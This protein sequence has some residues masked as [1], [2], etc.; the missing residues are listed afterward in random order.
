MASHSAYPRLRLLG[1]V[2]FVTAASCG[3]QAYDPGSSPAGAEVA[4]SAKGRAASA[5]VRAKTGMSHLPEPQSED[6]LRASLRRH[7][8]QHLQGRTGAVLLDVEVDARGT[9]LDVDVVTPPAAAAHPMHRAVISDGASN[10]RRAMKFRYDPAFGAAAQAA[11]RETRFTS[12]VRARD[13]RAVPFRWRMTVV[14]DPS[15]AS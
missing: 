13:D 4:Q 14:F 6:A 5:E 1:V 15:L 12:A 11:L 8:P 9:V 7:Y 2:T 3:P 10:V